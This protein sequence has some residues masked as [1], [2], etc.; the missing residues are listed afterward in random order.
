[1]LIKFGKGFVML[2][3]AISPN[4][5]HIKPQENAAVFHGYQHTL[6]GRSKKEIHCIIKP[7]N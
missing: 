4:T 7:N 5:S 1:M 2:Y 6:E 3:K